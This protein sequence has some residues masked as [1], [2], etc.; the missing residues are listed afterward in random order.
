LGDAAD[1]SAPVRGLRASGSFFRTVGFAPRLGREFD[2]TE[3]ETGEPPVVILGDAVWRA[4][5]GADPGIVGR[6][7]RLDGERRTVIGVLPN[8][9][10]FPPATDYDGYVIPFATHADPVDEGHNTNAIA[11]LRHGTS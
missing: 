6:Q 1:A 10:R 4:R 7:I 9:F 11:R 5:F 8:D 3:L 2:S